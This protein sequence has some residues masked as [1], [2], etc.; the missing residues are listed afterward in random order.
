MKLPPLPQE[1]G[2]YW[3]TNQHGHSELVTGHNYTAQQM[4]EYAEAA[5]DA[6]QAKLDRLMLEYC[7]E[8][9]TPEQLATWAKHQRPVL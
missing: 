6:L 2:T 7:P 1:E 4:L 5:C 9:M 8:E 3:E